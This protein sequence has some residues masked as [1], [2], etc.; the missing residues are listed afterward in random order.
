MT[1]A[2]RGILKL[3]GLGPVAGAMG[4]VTLP[5][6]A[7][8]QGISARLAL[9]IAAGSIRAEG[10]ANGK[11][12]LSSGRDPKWALFERLSRPH[13]RRERRRHLERALIGGWPP[14]IACM[15]SNAP[16]FRAQAAA[17]QIQREEE[18]ERSLIDLI[19]E[20]VFGKEDP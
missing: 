14:G 1:A 9:P 16:W 2:R 5:Q 13:Q 8:A 6:L 18:E 12:S 17:R 19:R 11:A 10:I 7:A 4:P 3:L 15:E 20:S